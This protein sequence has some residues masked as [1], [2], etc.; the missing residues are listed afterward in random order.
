MYFLPQYFQHAILFTDRENDNFE[1]K[2]W[3]YLSIGEK[4]RVRITD[5]PTFS[6]FQ[7]LGLYTIYILLIESLRGSFMKEVFA[8]L[9]MNA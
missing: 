3:S 2:T 6:C 4:N 1:T 5:M 8:V 9:Y 7:T